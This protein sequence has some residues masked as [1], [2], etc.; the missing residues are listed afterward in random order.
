[1]QETAQSQQLCYSLG[2]CRRRRLPKASSCAA[3]WSS[4]GARGC[5]A[6][7]GV[8]VSKALQEQEAARRQQVC[9][10]ARH[11]RCTRLLSASSCVVMR[12]PAGAEDWLKPAAVVLSG[13]LQV[14]EAAQRQQACGS[15]WA[16]RCKGLPHASRRAAL[17][18]GCQCGAAPLGALAQHRVEAGPMGLHAWQLH[19]V[20]WRLHFRDGQSQFGVAPTAKKVTFFVLLEPAA[21]RSPSPRL[22]QSCARGEHQPAL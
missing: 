14:Q 18:A 20:P 16:C 17:C 5:S 10:Y 6:P 22:A 7:T 12:D 11:C 9:G 4:A 3:L 2:L 13:A 15:V 19:T 21:W 1:M 8:W